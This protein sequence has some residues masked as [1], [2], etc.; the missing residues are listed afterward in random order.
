MSS[1]SIDLA[2]CTLDAYL[3][4][5]P[6]LEGLA[7]VL[8]D[9][10]DALELDAF[11]GEAP[12]RRD[13]LAD[14]VVLSV[15]DRG[16][17]QFV[18]R[19]GGDEV[20]FRFWRGP[21]RTADGRTYDDPYNLDAYEGAR[22]GLVGEREL[23]ELGYSA[24][25]RKIFAENGDKESRG[26]F[27]A[28]N[29]W[30]RQLVSW[31]VA[32][33]AGR[34]G[35]L[36]S[37]LAHLRRRQPQLFARWFQANGVDVA[38]GDYPALKAG[39][40]V[41]RRGVHVLIRTGELE[42]RGDRAWAFLRTQP[43]LLGLL[44]LAG[45]VPEIQGEQCRFWLERFLRPALRVRVR[46]VAIGALVTSEYGAGILARLYNM[47][48]TFVRTWSEAIFTEL[49]VATPGRDLADP[50]QWTAA[51]EAEF[52]RRI[53]DRRRILRGKDYGDYGASLSRERGSF[54]GPA[55]GDVDA[56]ASPR[57]DTRSKPDIDVTH[58]SPTE[59]RKRT[60][61]W[62]QITG[63]TLHQ[64]AVHGF[65][66]KVWPRVTAHLGVHSDGRVYW[67]HP[68][69]AYL[70]A[71]NGFNASTVAIEVAGNFRREEGSA[72][73]YWKKGRGP[74]ELTPTMVEG[75]R[76]AIRFVC[77]EVEHHGGKITRVHAHRQASINRP[78]CP[79]E[80]IWRAG[81]LWAQRELG[82]DDGGDGFKIGS[83]L[84]IPRAWDE[85]RGA[86]KRGD[87][88]PEPTWDG[89]EQ[90]AEFPD[91]DTA[92]E[93]AMTHRGVVL[94]HVPRGVSWTMTA[95]T[96]DVSTPRRRTSLHEA[97]PDL[98]AEAL[99]RDE[100]RL[101]AEIVLTPEPRSEVRRSGPAEAEAL[102]FDVPLRDD[103]GAVALIER[104]GAYHWLIAA[105]DP[106]HG[107]QRFHLPPAD[108]PTAGGVRR[109]LSGWWGRVKLRVF[110]FV[111]ARAARLAIGVFEGRRREGFVE[112]QGPHLNDW[113]PVERPSPAKRL[114]LLLHGTF[115]STV[116]CFGALS[117]AHGHELVTRAR[118]RSYCVVGFDHHTLGKTPA[119]N[120]RQIADA[121]TAAGPDDATIEIVCHSRGGLVARSLAHELARRGRRPIRSVVCV[122]T[123]EDGTKMADPT[124]WHELADVM[125]N[126]AA[127]SGLAWT[128]LGG[129]ALATVAVQAIVG[130]VASLIKWLAQGALDGET[131]PGLAAMTPG[132]ELR[133][134]YPPWD[135]ALCPRRLAVFS[136]FSAGSGLGEALRAPLLWAVDRVVDRL[137]GQAGN[138]LVVDN[139]STRFGAGDGVEL[140][141]IA[142]GAIHHIGFF[143][144]PEVASKLVTWLGLDAAPTDVAELV[145][146]LAQEF[147]L[148]HGLKALDGSQKSK[149]SA[150]ALQIGLSQKS[151]APA[152]MR[153]IDL[154]EALK[155]SAPSLAGELA[156]PTVA[157]A[158]PR[159]P[160]LSELWMHSHAAAAV[161]PGELFWVFVDLAPELATL[162]VAPGA[163]GRIEH[164]ELVEVELVARR[165]AE[166]GAAARVTVRAPDPGV[167]VRLGLSAR[168]LALG[169]VQ[170]RVV[171][172][173]RDV[174]VMH[175]EVE[176]EA[177]ADAIDAPLLTTEASNRALVGQ[178][179]RLPDHQ[180][181][182]ITLYEP[183][184]AIRLRYNLISPANDLR[185]PFETGRI[186]TD[187]ARFVDNLFARIEREWDKAE[188]NPAKFER[189]LPTIGSMLFTQLMPPPLR[190]LLWKHRDGLAGLQ[191]VSDEQFI[192]WELVYLTQADGQIVDGSRFLAE[193]GL[194]RSL[195]DAT[196]AAKIRVRNAYVVAPDYPPPSALRAS[197]AEQATL[198]AL[199][200]ARLLEPGAQD[201]LDLVQ[202]G[203]SFDLLHFICHGE[204]TDGDA[205][206]LLG[207]VRDGLWAEDNLASGEVAA[208]GSM[209]GPD[210]ERPLVFIN[211]CTVGRGQQLLTSMGGWASAF[212][213]RGAGAVVAPLW[214]VGDD[215][216]RHFARAFYETLHRGG[217][218]AE[219]VAQA[220]AAARRRNDPTWLAYAVY[221][222]PHGRLHLQPSQS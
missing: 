117:L 197:P 169:V 41:T 141:E 183:G 218:F 178:G 191:I 50:S 205:E 35:T 151:M 84:P 79:G 74:S 213:S 42:L 192:P 67:I 209:R 56:I 123:T 102:S 101:V 24:S 181:E 27:G 6:T 206:L 144:A 170:L 85:R 70:W 207:A 198:Q 26:K 97:E 142:G 143:A 108:L 180:L 114:L 32:Q 201:V 179:G 182:I 115:S 156:T 34:A 136:N 157:A 21:R 28:V 36:A 204:L 150:L 2:Y 90:D 30:D 127:A 139:D 31:G 73:T 57:R 174:V 168:A 202:R 161:R 40:Y 184:G 147:A 175:T 217:D 149:L 5:L 137:F 59:K 129:A 46:G 88:V 60:R 83:G 172:R 188:R 110:R 124:R 100:L 55:H 152:L 44:M 121:L 112:L 65:P 7:D 186:A 210:G 145:E 130:G 22:S 4:I 166:V 131:V 176:L 173:Q 14:A 80:A 43:R 93:A 155:A 72:G 99:V 190:E 12:D 1:P 20:H 116:G 211:A 19:G 105:E 194:V 98:V 200:A 119:E 215:A 195:W 128:A 196:L 61:Q 160:A 75:L 104:D 16:E 54:D 87:A 62:T 133:R 52:L 53:G 185:V 214:A 125:T 47:A 146:P 158:E 48:P 81:G 25:E 113:V 10:P 77:A 66:S 106:R 171:V 187:L 86:S 8:D 122:A 18:V 38:S 138:D 39:G 92:I 68:L 221:A 208:Y 163:K 220:R 159:T 9:E 165:N 82:L 154:P 140:H 134:D 29:T 148:L 103:E 63:I 33:F 96:G 135:A 216:A 58:L 37:L 76:R 212:L 78:A 126:L 49:E 109:G 132:D 15:E 164:D 189:I 120:A 17:R 153:G 199:F 95:A 11:V 69:Q 219:A 89:D 118:E 71:S 64:T 193:L 91:E 111:A 203:G 94:R 3:D 51:L 107:L 177:Q 222:D 162:G 13:G 167:S 45:N 23:A